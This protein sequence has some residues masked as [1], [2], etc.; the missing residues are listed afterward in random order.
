LYSR[1]DLLLGE[2]GLFVDFQNDFAFSEIVGHD[3]LGLW[4]D[5]W[6]KL[7]SSHKLRQL[8]DAFFSPV[9]SLKNSF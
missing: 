3:C 7:F 4:N 6:Y 1:H 5:G 8:K 9:K 2:G